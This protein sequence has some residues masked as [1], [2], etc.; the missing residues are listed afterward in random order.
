M[1][2]CLVCSKVQGK[3]VGII[4]CSGSIVCFKCLPE[5]IDSYLYL[6]KWR[7]G[8]KGKYKEEKI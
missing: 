6:R 3:K 1:M 7:E 8:M 2:K 4:S 5:V